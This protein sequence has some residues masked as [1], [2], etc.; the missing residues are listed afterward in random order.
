MYKKVIQL[1]EKNFFGNQIAIFQSDDNY[2][3]IMDDRGEI[4]Y[5][6]LDK[7]LQYLYPVNSYIKK[8]GYQYEFE[9][10]IETIGFDFKIDLNQYGHSPCPEY[11]KEIVK[12]YPLK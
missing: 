2:F 1:K 9:K 3:V 12:A 7:N 11:L 8:I 4:V 6:F 10:P 5:F